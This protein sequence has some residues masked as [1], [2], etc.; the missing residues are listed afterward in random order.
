LIKFYLIDRVLKTEITEDFLIDKEKSKVRSNRSK[1]TAEKKA[2]QLLEQTRHWVPKIKRLSKKDVF[3][4]SIDSYNNW[5]CDRFDVEPATL[6]SDK[7]FL[8]RI[9]VNYIRH[10]LTEYDYE[11]YDL[12]GKV[13]KQEAVCTVKCIMLDKIGELYPYLVDE[14]LRQKEPFTDSI[15]PFVFKT[16][17]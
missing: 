17:Q 4:K 6:N 8:D 2:I 16:D 1:K 13:G 3:N 5:N 12:F 7:E 9:T 15:D 10:N 14:C 11:L